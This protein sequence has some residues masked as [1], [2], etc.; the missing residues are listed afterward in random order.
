MIPVDFVGAG[1]AAD[2]Q[3]RQAIPREIA[4]GDPAHHKT[5]VIEK[6]ERVI[7]LHLRHHGHAGLGRRDGI[8]QLS[9]HSFGGRGKGLR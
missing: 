4:D 7:V 3:I 8:K 1:R 5:R 2:H 6:T 9:G